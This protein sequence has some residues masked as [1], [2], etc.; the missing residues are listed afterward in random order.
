M[1]LRVICSGRR[2]NTVIASAITAS[3]EEPEM[4]S[5]RAGRGGGVTTFCRATRF[6]CAPIRCTSTINE[7]ALRGPPLRPSRF[8]A[9]LKTIPPSREPHTGGK[10]PTAVLRRDSLEVP[11]SAFGPVRGRRRRAGIVARRRSRF[12]LGVSV[13]IR[14]RSGV[15]PLDTLVGDAGKPTTEQAPS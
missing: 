7:N 1:I 3:M 5:S 4:R 15:D 14:W 11:R 13:R 6:S 8:V 9:R 2:D 10:L 12:V